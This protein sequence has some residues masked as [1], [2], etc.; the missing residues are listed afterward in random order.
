MGV[1]RGQTN[2]RVVMEFFDKFPDVKAGDVVVTSSYSRL[3][4]KDIAVG[5]VESIDLTKSPAP[6]SYYSTFGP[7]ICFRV[8]CHSSFRTA[9]ISRY[10]NHSRTIRS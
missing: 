8:G 2:N 9:G 10:S 1:I 5:R 3:F 4:P 6:R 7:L